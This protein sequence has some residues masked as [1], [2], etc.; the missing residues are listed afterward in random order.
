MTPREAGYMT[1]RR[2]QAG[3]AVMADTTEFP[4][5]KGIPIPSV[6][7]GK[8]E[9]YPWSQLAVGDS[10]FVPPG[11]RISG[12]RGYRSRKGDGK[13]FTTRKMDGGIRVWR[14]K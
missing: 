1:E 10:F 13:K 9:K 8:I 5:E 3:V 7:G 2:K 11:M 6:R 12:Y 4:I 14:V